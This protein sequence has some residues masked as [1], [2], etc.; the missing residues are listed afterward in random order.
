MTPTPPLL[1]RLRSASIVWLI[2][3]AALVAGMMLRD[4]TWRATDRLRWVSDVRNAFYWGSRINRDIKASQ[5]DVVNT[6]GEF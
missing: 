6:P 3:C 5:S 4:W 1:R 2:V